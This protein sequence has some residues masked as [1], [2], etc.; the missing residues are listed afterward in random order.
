MTQ[1]LSGSMSMFRLVEFLN[2]RGPL[3]CQRAP[4]GVARARLAAGRATRLGTLA[5]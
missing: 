5:L 2:T 4:E 3:R 1:V